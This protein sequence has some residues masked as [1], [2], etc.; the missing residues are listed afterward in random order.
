MASSSLDIV[1]MAIAA[2]VGQIIPKIKAKHWAQISQ[3]MPE[4]R[5]LAR[6][7]Q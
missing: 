1:R 2:T 3:A 7:T 5:R 4:P 6:V